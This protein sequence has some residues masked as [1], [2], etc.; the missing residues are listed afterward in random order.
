MRL[1]LLGLPFAAIDQP[2]IFAYYARQNTL[3]PALVGLLGVGFYLVAALLPTLIRPLQMTDLVLAN[4]IQLTSHAVIMLW[5]TNRV[6]T[7]K[8]QYL[9][10]TTLKAGSAALTMGLILGLVLPILAHRVIV[11]SKYL[12]P[13]KRSEEAENILTEILDTIPVPL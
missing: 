3:A 13:Y 7:L 1:Y 9:G 2:L 12:S 4:S 8:G 11:S 5:L 10:S 6:A